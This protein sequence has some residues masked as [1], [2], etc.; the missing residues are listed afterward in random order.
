VKREFAERLK[1]EYIDEGRLGV[2]TG[3]GFYEYGA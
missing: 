1:S 2:A 3:R